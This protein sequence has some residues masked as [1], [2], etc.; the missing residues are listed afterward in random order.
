MNEFEE[1]SYFNI[2]KFNDIAGSLTAV[3]PSKVN[4]Q[5]SYIFE[6][7][8]ETIEAFENNNA[9]ELLDGA[10]DL[11]VTVCGLM[12]QLHAAGFNVQEAQKRVDANNL[13]KYP[14]VG[15]AIKYK[16]EHSYELNSKYQV[17]VIKD[18][19]GKIMKPLDFKPVQLSDL[20]PKDNFWKGW[21]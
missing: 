12:Q 6:E 9:V 3:T 7:L 4:N 13:S 14:K 1:Y 21:A 10:C 20:V 18:A 16:P 2:G 8:T 15:T 17:Y 11:F 5:L 19:G